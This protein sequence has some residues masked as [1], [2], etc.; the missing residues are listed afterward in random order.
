MCNCAGFFRRSLLLVT[1]AAASGCSTV[2]VRTQPPDA[3]VEV[4]GAPLPPEHEFRER[5]GFSSHRIVVTQ[6]G[7]ASQTLLLRRTRMHW[8]W[9]ALALSSVVAAAFSGTAGCLLG[10]LLGTRAAASMPILA[11]LQ[12]AGG[13]FENLLL[14]PLVVPASVVANVL[15]AGPWLVP[16]MAIGTLIGSWPLAALFVPLLYPVAGTDVDVTLRKHGAA[17]PPSTPAAPGSQPTSGA[18]V[19][20]LP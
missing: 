19:E 4:D 5:P 16:C 2:Q 11:G 14:L 13:N 7:Y 8:L 15:G 9:M 10:A 12:A 6:P 17:A 20:V 18:T 3:R 1:L